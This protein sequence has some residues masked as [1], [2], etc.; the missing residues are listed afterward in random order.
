MIQIV[1]HSKC[2]EIFCRY[3]DVDFI[4]PVSN[5][6]HKDSDFI[7]LDLKFV[8]LGHTSTRCFKLTEPPLQNANLTLFDRLFVRNKN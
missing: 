6:W 1:F 7:Y 3:S 4:F 8:N 5:N 2:K